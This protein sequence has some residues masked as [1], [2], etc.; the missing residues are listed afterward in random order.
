MSG[1]C[2]RVSKFINSFRSGG[3]DSA[4]SFIKAAAPA[5]TV[6]VLSISTGAV[7]NRALGLTVP[8]P[9]NALYDVIYVSAALLGIGIP[10][11]LTVLT[12]VGTFYESSAVPRLFERSMAVRSFVATV[13]IVLLAAIFFRSQYPKAEGIPNPLANSDLELATYLGFLLVILW[14]LWLLICG[15]R[16]IEPNIL[17]RTLRINLQTLSKTKVEEMRKRWIEQIQALSDLLSCQAKHSNFALVYRELN[18]LTAIPK[19]LDHLYST[20]PEKF[21]QFCNST[22]YETYQKSAYP[23]DSVYKTYSQE[24]HYITIISLFKIFVRLYRI[25]LLQQHSDLKRQVIFHLII[26]I[27]EMITYPATRKIGW[28]GLSELNQLLNQTIEADDALGFAVA[29][30]W[31][32]EL[33]VKPDLLDHQ[34]VDMLANEVF[35]LARVTIDSEKQRHFSIL[36]ES[37][38]MQTAGLQWPKDLLERFERGLNDKLPTECKEL[39]LLELLRWIKGMAP[40]AFQD[41]DVTFWWEKLEFIKKAIEG[42]ALVIEQKTKLLSELNQIKLAIKH[43]YLRACLLQVSCNIGAYCWHHKKWQFI[44]IL[45][46]LQHKQNS[47][48]MWSGRNLIPQTLS[49]YFLLI[50]ASNHFFQSQRKWTA[51]PDD[52]T[53]SLGDYMVALLCKLG[54]EI[55]SQSWSSIDLST[56]RIH[57]RFDRN[58]SLNQLSLAVDRF[59]MEDPS[60]LRELNLDAKIAQSLTDG[61]IQ[62]AISSVRRQLDQLYSKKEDG[63]LSYG[64]IEQFRRDFFSG[65]SQGRM[66]TILRLHNSYRDLTGQPA[67]HLQGDLLKR[68][69]TARTVSRSEFT[70]DSWFKLERGTYWGRLFSLAEDMNVIELILPDCEEIKDAGLDRKGLSH[71]WFAITTPEV[72][73]RLKIHHRFSNAKSE[74]V[75]GVTIP[76]LIGFFQIDSIKIPVLSVI[77]EGDD[78]KLRFERAEKPLDGKV[79][80]LDAR[81]IGYLLQYA[82]SETAKTNAEEGISVSVIELAKN[83]ELIDKIVAEQEDELTKAYGS[84]ENAREELKSDVYLAFEERFKFVP[85]NVKNHAFIYSL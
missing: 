10:I 69:A 51:T 17:L 70:E 72:Q 46:D 23:G 14:F 24:Q 79:L 13:A 40:T 1:I 22:E 48:W 33:A 56:L 47:T 29:C 18:N 42:S 63:P 4:V 8:N 67:G 25:S 16:L 52:S 66:R 3:L 58:G 15:A 84:I 35:N 34:I 38:I 45:W 2:S 80:F 77:D 26:L 74:L 75:D 59:S 7:L 11:G 39:N 83:N 5:V 62:E 28:L 20:D 12:L 37:L 36:I 21:L 61:V 6:V 54:Q 19:Q 64:Q 71:G 81:N 60:L 27:R 32:E 73:E 53:R 9:E 49:E 76:G 31:F 50:T 82:C 30:T 85:G 41:N 57:K 43:V 44:K 68:H 55:P 65:F 78:P